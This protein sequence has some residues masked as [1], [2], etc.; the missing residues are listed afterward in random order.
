MCGFIA[1]LV[2]HRTGIAEVM[3]SN[4]VEAL[5]FFR[6][7]LS[8]CLNWKIYCDDHT[9]LS[10]HTAV[11]IWIISYIFHMISLHGKKWTQQIDLAPNVW[12]HSSVGRAS[13]RYRGGHGFESRWSPDFF[14]ASSFQLLKLE[15]LLRWSHFTF[16]SYCS[17]N[18]N[19]FIYISQRKS[20]AKIFASLPFLTYLCNK[21][22]KPSIHCV[23]L[24]RKK[25]QIA[26]QFPHLSV[27][28]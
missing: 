25:V 15:N 22:V 7:L 12:L 3:G 19:Y 13:H 5:I 18:M 27:F 16:I 26:L 9:S 14:Q 17:T 23:H 1:Q 4:P 2:E 20:W 28:W 11:Q 8:N 6:L 24:W 21:R 10:S